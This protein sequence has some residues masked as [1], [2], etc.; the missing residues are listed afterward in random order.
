[1]AATHPVIKPA[2]EVVVALSGGVDS[3]MAAVLLQTAGWEVHGLHFLL[4]TAPSMRQSRINAVE[5]VA[6]H[7]KIPV[8]ML[9]V[10]EVFCR[11]VIDPFVDAYLAGRTPNPCV[12]C[13]QRIKFEYLLNYAQSRGILY[14]ATGHYAR[15]RKKIESPGFELW[16]GADG[17]KE[18]S[19]FLHRLNQRHLSRTVFPLA[20]KRKEALRKQARDVG[21]PVHSASESQE[22]CFLPEKDY[23]P[24]VEQREGPEVNREGSIVNEEGTIVGTHR[25]AFRYTIGQRRGLG[26]AA[27]RP[28]YVKEIRPETNTVVVARKETLYTRRVEATA[29]NW[30]EGMPSQSVIEAQAQIRYRH[31]PASGQ[32][33]II[34]SDKVSFTFDQPQ[35][36]VTPGQAL[37]CY[38][39]DRL[40]GGGW[41]NAY[42]TG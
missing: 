1:M 8:E 21:L 42:P 3:S 29:F 6:K 13:N 25:G 17:A 36:A 15:I 37:V 12:V 33:R 23:R 18:Q 19:Y 9:D 4:P 30:I 2:P 27:A 28:Y 7:L 16:R 20:E 31:K 34:S 39:G 11:S 38:R 32:L 41:I 26:V 5:R 35:W 24:L 10:G 22:I 40:I 14:I